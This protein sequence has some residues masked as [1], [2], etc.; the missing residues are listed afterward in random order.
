MKGRGWRERE[1]E[2]DRD[3]ERKRDIKSER[4][5]DSI[6]NTKRWTRKYYKKL[7]QEKV[8][9]KLSPNIL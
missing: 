6:G 7:S 5:R 1:S 9:K 3:S 2:R 4:D 8:D